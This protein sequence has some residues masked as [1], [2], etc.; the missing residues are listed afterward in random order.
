M[1]SKLDPQANHIHQPSQFQ[2]QFQAPP[3]APLPTYAPQPSYVLN[4]KNW[5][6]APPMLFQNLT[7][8]LG[9][10]PQQTQKKRNPKNYCWT[11][12]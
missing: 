10:Q 11:H 2:Q 8:L 7:K 12:G 6:M 5:T 4:G 9:Y 1:V 3:Q